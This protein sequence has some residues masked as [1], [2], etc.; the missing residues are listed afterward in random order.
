MAELI[1]RHARDTRPLDAAAW[2]SPAGTSGDRLATKVGHMTALIGAPL[3]I[4]SPVRSALLAKVA[5]VLALA[6]AAVHL[7]LLDAASFGSVVMLGMALAC[8]PC[9]W[10]LWRGPTA[11][12]WGLTAAVDTGMLL[13]HAETL[14]TVPHHL[15]GTSHSLMWTGF[16]LVT[17][18]LVLAGAADARARRHT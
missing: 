6:A 16:G 11:T 8:L 15:H 10:H 2:S 5:A 7:L 17:S 4:D 1:A 12:V 13:V 18:Q 14:A 9:A 3:A